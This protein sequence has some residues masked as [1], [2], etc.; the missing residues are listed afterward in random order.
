MLASIIREELAPLKNA[1]VQKIAVSRDPKKLG[2]AYRHTPPPASPVEGQ[3][4]QEMAT[5]N[6]HSPNAV[7]ALHGAT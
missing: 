1:V 4:S 2:L 6:Q 7:T 3:V 5:Q